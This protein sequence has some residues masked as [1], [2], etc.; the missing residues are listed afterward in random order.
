[1]LPYDKTDP[2]SIEAYAKGLA[3]KT[4]SQVLEE[5]RYLDFAVKDSKI[6]YSNPN[7]KGKLGNLLEE[8]YF[9]YKANSD[10]EADFAEAGVELKVTCYDV[11]KNGS[12]SAGERLVLTM[13]SYEGPV[14]KDFYQS[15]VWK[16]CR[17][18][19]LVYYERDKKLAYNT[20]YRITFANMV[21]PA[22]Q[23]MPIIVQDYNKIIQ[24]MESGKA[25]ELSESD[26]L[27]LGACTKGATA[28]SSM[29]PQFYP[30]YTPARKRAFCFK[31]QYMDYLLHTY[32]M[33]GRTTYEPLIRDAEE[34]AG[35]TFEEVITSRIACHYGA[36]DKELCDLYGREYNKNKAQWYDLAYRMLGI[37]GNHAEEFQKANIVVKVIRLEE[38]NTMKE[39]MS[40]PPFK[41]KELAEQTWEDSDIFRYF[42]ETR[43]FFVIFKKAG[44][45]YYLHKCQFW[46]MP[47]RDLNETVRDG[48][49][50]V[51]ERIINGVSFHISPTKTGHIIHNNL[52]AKKD[53]RII[54]VRP[55]AAK[56]AYKLDGFVLG[57]I[58][59]DADELPSGECMTRQSFWINN[60]YLLGQLE[61]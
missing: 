4:F 42:D 46:N 19:L 57:N 56:S 15:H 23:D 34:L 60:S 44:D 55:H 25:D 37:R 49:E 51:K 9:G 50:R 38:N 28:A 59:R 29:R 41:F 5:S 32:I 30:P 43:F 18:I 35:R 1:M 7:Q 17:R 6:D 36:T 24:K 58:E 10:Q 40:F 3:G 33:P 54:H 13:I 48:W 61:V 2:A 14:E 27:Y 39:S 12:I 31:R 53:N 11:L 20:L 21:S 45:V 52:P 47:Y 26:T 16:K 22:R 8:K